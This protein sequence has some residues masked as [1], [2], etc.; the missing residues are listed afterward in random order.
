MKDE[1][2]TEKK[3]Q[4]KLRISSYKEFEPCFEY[5]SAFN[6]QDSKTDSQ[7]KKIYPWWEKLLNGGKN[8]T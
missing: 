7:K 3:K 5:D 8:S 4:Q 6:C 2:K 1:Q